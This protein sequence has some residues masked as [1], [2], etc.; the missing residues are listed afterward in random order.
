MHP[1]YLNSSLIAQAR[2]V[3]GVS[4][5]YVCTQISRVAVR[6]MPNDHPAKSYYAGRTNISRGLVR[7]LL[8]DDSQN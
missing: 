2:L 7:Q 3:L 5:V 1:H 6:V 8:R 4:L